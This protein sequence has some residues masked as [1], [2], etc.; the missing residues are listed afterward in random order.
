MGRCSVQ[1]IARSFKNSLQV[2]I[3]MTMGPSSRQAG[4]RLEGRTVGNLRPV[5]TV[6]DSSKVSNRGPVPERDDPYM[7]ARNIVSWSAFGPP[8]LQRSHVQG[9]MVEPWGKT[10]MQWSNVQGRIFTSS[11]NLM[12]ARQCLEPAQVMVA[13][14]GLQP[15]QW[16]NV[17]A[18]RQDLRRAK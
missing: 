9:R 17:M 6:N 7:V 10:N 16:K 12:V 8:A 1:K 2:Y 11:P 14:C 18:A 5:P 3:L 4:G 13:R 15:S